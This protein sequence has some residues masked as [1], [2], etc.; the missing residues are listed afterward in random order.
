M[1]I[2]QLILSNATI[3]SNY[4]ILSNSINLIYRKIKA[5]STVEWMGIRINDQN[6]RKTDERQSIGIKPKKA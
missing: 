3:K 5:S 1:S 4:H 2:I 6:R